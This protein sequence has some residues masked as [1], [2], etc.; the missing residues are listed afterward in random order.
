MRLSW[1]GDFSDL[2]CSG[3]E[4][5]CLCKK[6]ERRQL[7]APVERTVR[8]RMN[9]SPSSGRELQEADEG[10]TA[11]GEFSVKVIISSGGFSLGGLGASLVMMMGLVV[12]TLL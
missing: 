1:N 9:A 12:V 4:R 6:D 10:F 3:P 7:E 8:F 11:S 5:W 2:E